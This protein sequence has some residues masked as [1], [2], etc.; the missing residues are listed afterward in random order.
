MEAHMT[1]IELATKLGI[2][3][4]HLSE[5]ESGKHYPSVPLLFQIA[6]LCN[7]ST[8]DLYKVMD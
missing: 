6:K 2:K 3:N 4:S 1:Q 7:C 5:I 8:D